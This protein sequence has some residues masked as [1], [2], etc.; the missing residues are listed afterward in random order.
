MTISLCKRELS[1]YMR[2]IT[3]EEGCIELIVQ[4][5]EASSLFDER[6]VINVTEGRGSIKANRP[7]ALLLGVYDFL[8]RLGCRFLRPGVKGEVIPTLNI[9]DV[10]VKAEVIPANR[11]R[12]ITIEGAVSLEN[13]L[14]LIEWAPKVGFNSYFIQFRTAYD[15]F[16]RW[17]TH[18]N[19]PL[20]PGRSFTEE[21]S[22][23][24]V[25]RVVEKIK[26]RDMIY[27][28]VGHGW[29]AACIGVDING[30]KGVEDSTL[31]DGQRQLLAEIAGKRGYF[32]NIPMNTHLCYSN[33]TVRDRL[34]NEVVT[35]A[36][37]HPEIDVLHFWLADDS[38]NVCECAECGKKRLADWYVQ[39]LNLIDKG[40]TERGVNT[41]ICF[42]VYLDLY[43]PP[44]DERILN[45]D[46]F[47][48]MFAPI[49]RTYTKAY[50]PTL[51]PENL[52]YKVNKVV[53]PHTS[54]PYVE[55][56]RGWQK[57]FKGDSFD[58]D[59]HLM[60]DIN[61][62]FGGETLASVLYSDV[63]S[64][65]Q[66]GLNGFMSCQIQRAFYPSGFA[67]YLM[68]RA[69]SDGTLSFEDIRDEYYSAA[70]SEHAEFAKKAYCEVER[71]VPFAYMRDEIGADVAMP[72][73]KEGREV[74]KE[75]ISGLPEDDDPVV[76]ESL[77]LLGF[78]LKNVQNLIEVLVLK[79]EGADADVI[80]KAN[81]ARKQFF[82]S[83][84][85]RFQPYADGFYVNMIVDGIVDATEVGIYAE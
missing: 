79:A 51:P 12:G 5:D 41:K 34:V 40:L 74:V 77:A 49:F 20:L 81:A 9:N 82:N 57:I 11:H 72:L 16:E 24:L 70:F 56:L 84:E 32:K 23:Q 67:F 53:Y 31:S 44:K 27:H 2:R 18:K 47:L 28:A 10:T 50:D 71:T 29:T 7:R 42:L 39:M 4:K 66:M 58:F 38:N 6:Y 76:S 65:K 63:R 1:S 43:W 19:N 35:Y 54:A 69:L 22:A 75:L 52:E 85:L 61:R 64:L 8:R 36:E 46:R 73:L 78:M 30:W 14:E 37:E 26:E 3:G 25:K 59:Y 62:D 68:G 15:F 33:P 13:V 83:N 55:F 48:L 21:E 80:A 45:E 17:Y 60:W